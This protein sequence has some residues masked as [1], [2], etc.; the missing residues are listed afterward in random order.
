MQNLD[1]KGKKITIMGLGVHGGGLAVTK[2]LAQKGALLTVTDLRSAKLLANSL[3][4]LKKY[5]KN[6][7][8]VLGEHRIADF[9]KADM[10]IKNPGVRRDSK[11]LQAAIAHKVLI[12]TD[13]SLF[14]KL[15][16]SDRILGITGTKGKSTT[17][18]LVYKIIKAYKK[19][20]IM[21]GNIRVSPLD[22]LSK[23][24]KDIPVIL[25]LS[26]WQLEG[27]GE[28]K[29]S[30]KYALVTNVMRDHLNTY[31]GMA[32]YT[33]AKSLIWKYQTRDNF[34]VLNKD[35]NYTRQMGS[36]AKSQVFWFSLNKL[37][38]QENGAYISD[39]WIY[40]QRNGKREKVINV[41]ELKLKG[42]HNLLNIMGAVVL[43]RVFGVPFLIIKKVV[44]GFNGIEGRMQLVRAYKGI[45]YINDTTATTPDAVIAALNSL[46]Q[47]VVLLAG[48]TDKKLEFKDM[49]RVLKSKVK[50]LILFEGTATEK[51]VKELNKINF[52]EN[53]VFVDSMS[54][55]F[56]Q[57][58]Y[59]LKK[60]DTF[61]LSPGAASFGL[62]INEFD[63]G[64]QFNSAV[65]K[66]K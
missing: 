18:S 19:G 46:E 37:K 54:E 1:F 57:A 20:A 55:A 28:T 42:E 10:I 12:E 27:L 49:A 11:Y 7:K 34:I 51:L 52:N 5:K 3:N 59:I 2:F 30:P 38:I 44:A 8:Y 6:I 47:K 35:N 45:K 13:L 23:I 40:Y 61:L 16:Q 29:T 63:R 66:I 21:G 48:G 15:C 26:S 65:K 9:I 39:G 64:D 4:Q 60:G 62:F 36:K 32:D 17:T 22:Y 43:T 53:L 25:E 33:A 56:K 14:F 24:K 50:A 31:R 41:G 58:K